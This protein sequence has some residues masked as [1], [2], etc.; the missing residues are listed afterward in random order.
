MKEQLLALFEPLKNLH[1]IVYTLVIA[2]VPLIELRGAIPAAMA[3]GGLSAWPAFLWSVLGSMIPAFFVIPLFAWAL[4]F[5]KERHWLPWLTNFLNRHFVQKAE[6][7]AAQQEE[8]T[9]SDKKSWQK[10]LLKFWAIVVFVAIPLP[11]TGVYTGSA[12]ASLIKMPF[13][14]AF[15]AV[16]LGDIIAGLIVMSLSAG[17]IALV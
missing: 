14:K 12:I 4:K 7:V 8:I 15:L 10:E 2:L 5:L 1:P 17:V 3:L 6:K 13:W 16:L 11:G 9:G